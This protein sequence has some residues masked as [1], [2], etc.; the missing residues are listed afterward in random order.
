MS[1]KDDKKL[2]DYP[3]FRNLEEINRNRQ[4]AFVGCLLLTL[5][6]SL[7][8]C[9]GWLA[10][11]VEITEIKTS[12]GIDANRRP[13]DVASEFPTGTNGVYC[14]FSWKNAP[15]NLPMKVRWFYTS[16]DIHIL[17]YPLTLTRVSDN[18][19]LSLRM[20]SGKILP[21]GSYRLDLEVKGKVI[22]SIS[23]A[24]LEPSQSS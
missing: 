1:V 6:L 2:I 21:S 12:L 10:P 9:K 18:G 13:V 16:G 22:K 20:P 4:T 15:L 7:W 14:W 23:F 24:V 8:G 11:S 3:L 19:A 17:D 5:L